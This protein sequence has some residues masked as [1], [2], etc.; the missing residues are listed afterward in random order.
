MAGVDPAQTYNLLEQLLIYT[1]VRQ[2]GVMISV[3][4]PAPE[5][6]RLFD[7]VL[8]L[9]RGKTLFHGHRL[10]ALPY[11]QQLGYGHSS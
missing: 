1:R 9:S 10:D 8:L 7:R 5:V 11:F 3:E 4:H 2:M 6:F